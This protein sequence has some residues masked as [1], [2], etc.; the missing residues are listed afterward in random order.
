[1]FFLFPR[2]RY[3]AFS[4]FHLALP[5]DRERSL[6]INLQNRPIYFENSPLE[7]VRAWRRH[8]APPSP[9]SRR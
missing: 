6:P 2:Y 7:S 3:A 8:G 1:M 9:F 4:S 5:Q